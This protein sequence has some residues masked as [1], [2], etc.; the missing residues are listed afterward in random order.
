MSL[1]DRTGLQG[2]QVQPSQSKTL[3]I[4]CGA[5]AR[6]LVAVLKAGRFD[7]IAIKCLPAELHN[8]P[9]KIPDSVRN[10]IEAEKH[11][12]ASIFVAY[13]D[14]GTGGQLDRVLADYGVERL[15]GAHC[16]E[17]FAGSAQFAQLHEEELGTFYLTDF[18][19]RHF[20]RLVLEGLGIDRHP[21]LLP[22]YFGNY[23]RV[24]YLAQQHSS[25]L[26][27][28]A[29]AH[30]RRLGLDFEMRKPGLE[31]FAHALQPITN[32]AAGQQG[33]S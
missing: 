26:E 24:V 27:T 5:I 22:M 17:F 21:E 28:N 1:P 10:L 31:E 15:P 9:E 13:A 23:K 20:E 30:A 8:T 11:R 32:A 29:R 25:E 19:V 12:H 3:V 14:C 6:E 4:A 16:Y 18:L 7:H 2:E 33:I